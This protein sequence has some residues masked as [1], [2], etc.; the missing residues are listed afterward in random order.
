[1][2]E[3]NIIINEFIIFQALGQQSVFV[4]LENGEVIVYKRDMNNCW[5]ALDRQVVSIGTPAAPVTRM[6]V[7]T[8]KIWCSSF[9]T[10]KIL[11]PA[12]IQIEVSLI[13]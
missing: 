2:L 7:V 3:I 1:M 4:S 11:N 5:S 12:N 10:I 13:P 9:N 8:G 6:I